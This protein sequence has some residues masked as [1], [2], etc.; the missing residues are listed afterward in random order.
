MKV[1]G[2]REME[3][4][5]RSCRTLRRC[6]RERA[7]AFVNTYIRFNLRRNPGRA[8]VLEKFFLLLHHNA[9]L[10]G[11]RVLLLCSTSPPCYSSET[12]RTIVRGSPTKN[13]NVRALSIRNSGFLRNTNASAVGQ[14]YLLCPLPPL[15]P[16]RGQKVKG[17]RDR[18]TSF[19]ILSGRYRVPLSSGVCTQSRA[20]I[21]WLCGFPRHPFHLRFL[22]L[23][24]PYVDHPL[25]RSQQLFRCWDSRRAYVSPS[26][27]PIFPRK[28]RPRKYS[29]RYPRISANIL[30]DVVSW[31][32]APITTLPMLPPLP[33]PLLIFRSS[34]P[35]A[36]IDRHRRHTHNDCTI[37]ILSQQDTLG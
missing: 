11:L 31:T 22:R 29:S 6:A 32:F 5:R 21:G 33:S 27:S 25:G 28:H 19:A 13:Q 8:T 36:R 20:D 10:A 14:R 1:S 18:D 3:K 15:F 9:C 7:S 23:A 26:V 16:P 4:F 24:Y 35:A 34:T 37:F 2:V 12:K 30:R 17:T